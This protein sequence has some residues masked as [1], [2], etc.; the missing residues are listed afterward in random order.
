MNKDPYFTKRVTFGLKENINLEEK[1][2]NYIYTLTRIFQNYK[3]KY[4]L[5]M[6]LEDG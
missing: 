4:I 1:M 6:N 2:N 3:R 5:F